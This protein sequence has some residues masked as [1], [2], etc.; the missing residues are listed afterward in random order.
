[1]HFV[2]NLVGSLYHTHRDRF[3]SKNNLTGNMTERVIQ[4]YDSLTVLRFP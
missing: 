4:I 1:M 3:L 2:S